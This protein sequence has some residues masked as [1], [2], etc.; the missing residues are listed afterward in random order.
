MREIS[1]RFDAPLRDLATIELSHKPWFA[2]QGYL[3]D[4]SFFGLLG[5]DQVES[6]DYSNYE[7]ADHIVDLNQGRMPDH[8]LQAYDFIVDG[9]TLEHVF[10]VPNVLLNI[11]SMLRT[12]G[13]IL[14]MAP[15]SNHMDHGFYMFSP[16]LFSDFYC[17]NKF[18][19]NLSQ[20]YRHTTDHVA[21]PWDVIDYEPGCL[22]GV[23]FGGLDDSIYG[24]VFIATK[25]DESTG[26]AIPQQGLA[27]R[28]MAASADPAPGLGA[29]SFVSSARRVVGAIPVARDL[30]RIAGA[31]RRRLLNLRRRGRPELHVKARY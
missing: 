28:E 27:R 14:H 3:S 25:T 8:L 29:V 19:T 23:S 30:W 6:L 1:A 11:F 22:D 10:H 15:S 16:T 26:H 5:F 17:A 21:D 2:Q 20:V 18:E 31:V 9:G 12:G 13:R 4:R 7:G 24:V